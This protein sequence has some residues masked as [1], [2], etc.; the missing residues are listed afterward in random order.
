MRSKPFR[1]RWSNRE[2]ASKPNV[3]PAGELVTD[4]LRKLNAL[5]N[6]AASHTLSVLQSFNQACT[7]SVSTNSPHTLTCNPRSAFVVNDEPNGL[8]AREDG[9]NFH[10]E[11][12]KTKPCTFKAAKVTVGT[13]VMQ[14]QCVPTTSDFCL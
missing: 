13:P 5:L 10:S 8:P 7:R 2:R 14:R 12:V 4:S 9:A 11:K 1:K 3:H 6:E